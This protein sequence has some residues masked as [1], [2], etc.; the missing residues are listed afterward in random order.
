YGGVALWTDEST[1]LRFLNEGLPKTGINRITQNDLIDCINAVVC[2]DS[3]AYIRCGFD[4]TAIGRSN[5]QP[6]QF[7]LSQNFP[8]PFNNE[9]VIPYQIN[10]AD[11]ADLSIFN[12]LGRKI[13]TLVSAKHAP[14]SY[15][16]HWNSNGYASGIYYARL[17]V[18][19]SSQIKKMILLK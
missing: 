4:P 7:N 6:V 18:G 16:A 10:Q 17:K 14:G 5:M 13:L 19:E 3:G 1:D 15:V 12:T 2:T 11:F 9:T 8:N